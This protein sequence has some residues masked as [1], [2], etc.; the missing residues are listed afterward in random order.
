MGFNN[1]GMERVYAHLIEFRKIVEWQLT[2][3]RAKELQWRNEKK[4]K[5]R[6]K[7]M[8]ERVNQ[9]YTS[10]G[11]DPGM[12]N[13]A[14]EDAVEYAVRTSNS[15]HDIPMIVGVNLGKNKTTED[16]VKDYT[17]LIHRLGGL[18]DYLV[19]NI[20]SP[21]TPGLRDLQRK[22]HLTT[23]LS[24]CLE[25]R[26]S[27]ARRVPLLV[28]VAPDLTVSERAE[29]AQVCLSLGV[30][31][32]IVSNTTISRPESLQSPYRTQ[33]GGLSGHALRNLSTET[34]ADMYVLTGGMLPII[35][36]GGVSSAED[37]MDKITAGASLVQMYSGLVYK[38]PQLIRDVKMGLS[39][40]LE[41]KGATNVSQLVGENALTVSPWAKSRGEA[42]V[43]KYLSETRQRHVEDRR[44]KGWG[45]I[46]PRQVYKL[47]NEV[48]LV[49]G[50]KK[51]LDSNQGT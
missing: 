45:L 7:L 20:S 6:D 12:S 36:V 37:A 9:R 47:G 17:S 42:E 3:G 44:K 29:I 28:K 1:Q 43:L 24:S 50:L 22:E 18:A 11:A 46:E 2:R 51:G 41:A 21:N 35:G 32:L 40:M 38:G 14:I 33:T 31:G 26:D 16:P 19:I 4:A 25:A 23:L 49:E 27:L 15:V 10:G 5:L 8:Q 30:D 34:V 48:S 39:D 13:E